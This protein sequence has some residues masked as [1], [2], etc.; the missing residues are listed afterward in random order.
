MSGSQAPKP[1]SLD[2]FIRPILYYSCILRSAAL[3]KIK[4]SAL[5]KIKIL[6]T[7]SSSHYYINDQCRA[8]SIFGI[9]YIPV[10]YYFGQIR[11]TG[12]L[13]L[14]C[15][16]MSR[17][18]PSFT[19]YSEKPSFTVYSKIPSKREKPSKSKK[20]LKNGMPRYTA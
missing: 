19:V 18:K 15:K 11:C 14:F 9:L 5:W 10:Y 17:K 8:N 3:W 4:M 2:P 1:P 20:T 6:S 13:K 7:K 12:I 16:T